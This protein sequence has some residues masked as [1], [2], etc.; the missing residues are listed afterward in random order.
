MKNVLIACAILASTGCATQSFVL[1]ENS[2]PMPTK[3]VMQPFFVSG[4]GQTQEMNPVGVCGGVE[5]IAKI[6]THM[7]FMDGFLGAISSGIYTPRQATVYC[8]RDSYSPEG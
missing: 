7:S 3:E 2:E 8:V 6:E 1:N 5:N 4:I